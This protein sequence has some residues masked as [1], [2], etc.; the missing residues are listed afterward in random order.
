MRSISLCVYVLVI[1]VA[2]QKKPNWLICHL[3]C[4]LACHMGPRYHILDGDTYS[5]H[6]TT[7]IEWSVHGAD[8]SGCYHYCINLLFLTTDSCGSKEPSVRWVP[9]WHLDS[10]SSSP[11]NKLKLSKWN[12]A[13]SKHASP[14]QEFSCYIGSRS[15]TCHTA[16]VTFPPYAKYTE[17]QT[18]TVL[19]VRG[20][21][22]QCPPQMKFLVSAFGQL[23]WKISDCM[24]VICL[25]LHICTYNRP[26]FSCDRPPLR[27]PMAPQTAGAR[28]DPEHRNTDHTT[29][30]KRSHL[31]THHM[32]VTEP[33]NCR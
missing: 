29:C 15:V 1:T 26:I 30:S 33:K 3:G 5:C 2:L 6:L 10:F 11:I 4:W 17:T 9:K 16:E 18:G 22:P 21:A 20:L 7:Y 25:K 28:T 12:I 13:V 19:R 32:Q 24:L 27:R 23:G 14:L 31:R 8:M